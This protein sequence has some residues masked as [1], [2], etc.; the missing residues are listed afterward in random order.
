MR[1]YREGFSQGQLWMKRILLHH[2]RQLALPFPVQRLAVERHVTGSDLSATAY[3][4]QKRRL[5][6]AFTHRR[7]PRV[8][9]LMHKVAKMVT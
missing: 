7:N 9:T 2:V 1:L 5:S 4:V 6:G 8:N 3:R